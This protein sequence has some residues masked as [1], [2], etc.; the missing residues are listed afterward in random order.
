VLGALGLLLAA[1]GLYSVVSYSVN[2][3]THE[4]GVRMALGAQRLD[5]LALVLRRGMTLTAIGV[6]A[7]SAL[8]LAFSHSLPGAVINN[9]PPGRSVVDPLIY[10]TAA[11]FLSLIAALATYLPARRAT[12]VDPMV[13][14]RYE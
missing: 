1:L 7:G 11:A 4:I 5:V 3:C 10:V 2:Q 12:R 13:A 14:L 9:I 6:A 8:A